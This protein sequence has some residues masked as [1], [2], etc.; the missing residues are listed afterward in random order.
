MGRSQKV[1]AMW[2][3]TLL[4]KWLGVVT[5]LAGSMWLGLRWQEMRV[6]SAEIA[7]DAAPISNA[8]YLPSVRRARSQGSWSP[9]IAVEGAPTARHESAFVQVGNR[10]YLLGGRGSRPVDVYDPVANTWQP[11]SYPPIEIH[12]FQAVVYN[13][14]I[15]ILGAYTGPFP[16]EDDISAVIIYDPAHDTWQIGPAGIDRP[17]GSAGAVLYNGQIYLVGGVIG[18]HGPQATTVGWFDAFNPC[19]H[20]WT[21]L[22]DMPHPRDHFQVVVVED[23]L[24]AAGG[25]ITGSDNFADNT[26]GPVDIF[27]F[28][29]GSWSSLPS[30]AGDIPTMRAGS[31]T[32]V[33]DDEVIVI[34]GEGFG[35]A[36]PATE[37]LNIHS[38][39]W[40]P[41]APL[42][43]ARHASQVINCHGGL[44]VAAGSGAQGGAP[45]LNSMEVFFMGVPAPCI[46]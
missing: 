46:P 45:E 11:A 37:A 32:T 33:I 22:P 25:R 1:E 28:A 44:Y 18:G 23:K 8:A 5:I 41:L 38:L 31:M 13:N 40:R 26:I 2:R 9:V 14:L 16:Y 7:P 19:T 30:P 17:R 10:F 6:D 42:L 21:S 43:Q 15:Y 20:T 24:Y 34:G 27:D 4:L 29:S 12:H 3:S 36:W 35:L 39:T